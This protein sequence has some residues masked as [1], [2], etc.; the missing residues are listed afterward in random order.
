M[1]IISKLYG[2][3]LII[4]IITVSIL[5]NFSFAQTQPQPLGPPETVEE[6]KEIGKGLLEKLPRTLE[7]IWKEEVLPFLKKISNWLKE[8]IWDSYI[9]P[10]FKKEIEKRKPIIK[11]EFKKE[12]E[13]LR[14]EVP[15]VGKSLWQ[16]FKELIK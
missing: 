1:R 11:E 2:N 6:A 15:K 12:K 10:F 4:L 16:K 14:E 13:E 7:K 9:G 5:P 8:K 3:T